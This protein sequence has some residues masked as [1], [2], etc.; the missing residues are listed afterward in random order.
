M[1]FDL[2]SRVS[3]SCRRADA[4]WH[5]NFWNLQKIFTLERKTEKLHYFMF[6][7]QFD[8]VFPV[9][10]VFMTFFA[11]NFQSE[12]SDCSK[13]ITFRKS[14]FEFI[15]FMTVCVVFVYSSP[16]AFLMV[17]FSLMCSIYYGPAI[18]LKTLKTLP[19]I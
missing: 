1:I 8:K 2:F 16:S 4:H 19:K 12:N 10:I 15:S 14:A 3:K 13:E 9:F 5:N 17:Y 6:L 11:Q 18:Q 7:S